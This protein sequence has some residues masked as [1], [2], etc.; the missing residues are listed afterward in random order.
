MADDELPFLRITMIGA[1]G[2]GKTSLIEAFVNNAV[3]PG[4]PTTTSPTL[5]Y[6]VVRLSQLEGDD[7]KKQQH[8]DHG[9]RVLVEIEDT[10]GSDGI[11]T[12]SGTDQAMTITPFYDLW[13]P[14][15]N[16]HSTSV[17]NTEP[18]KKSLPKKDDAN[19]PLNPFQAPLDGK[20]RPLTRNRMAYMICFDSTD[21]GSF[22]EALKACKI[23]RLSTSK[24]EHE[25]P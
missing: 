6:T 19:I 5:S 14:G 9:S 7:H 11:G 22:K 10:F 20:F 3:S 21:T 23:F 4:I 12:V 18:K 13:W 15:I 2:S 1:A 24:L 25:A 17:H 8:V 16:A